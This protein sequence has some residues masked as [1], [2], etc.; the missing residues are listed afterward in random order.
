M[1]FTQL[2]YVIALAEEGSFAR[3]S[4]RCHVTQPTLSMQLNKLEEHLGVTLFDRNKRPVR[5]TR[6]GEKVIEQARLVLREAD[7]I[8]ELI[9]EAEENLSGEVRLGVIPTVAPY[10]LPLFLPGFLSRYPDLRIQIQEMNTENVLQ[11][12]RLDK[13]DLGVMATPLQ[14]PDIQEHPLY[15]EELFAYFSTDHPFAGNTH[16]LPD[17]LRADELLLLEEGHCMRSQVLNLCNLQ[18]Q[19]QKNSH[20]SYEAGSVETLKNLVEAGQGITIVPE[21]SVAEMGEA[22]RKTRIGRFK[23]RAPVRQISL[24]TYRHYIQKQLLEALKSEIRSVLPHSM[25]SSEGK[26]VME[27]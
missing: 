15:Y 20:F 23:G 12:L 13:L 18:L 5:P 7:R 25:L 1:T 3:A 24:V 4:A 2:S 27:I 11:Q 6:I 9:T 21:L 26:T 10:L 19:A 16:L 14:Q 17:N 8:P 22:E